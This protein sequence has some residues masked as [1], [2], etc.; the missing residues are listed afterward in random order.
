M[1]TANHEK[2]RG[3]EAWCVVFGRVLAACGEPWM[4]AR[5]HARGEVGWFEVWFK[6]HRWHLRPEHPLKASPI[7]VASS[8][9]RLLSVCVTQVTSVHGAQGMH[10]LTMFRTLWNE[11]EK[12]TR[13]FRR[14]HSHLVSR[15]QVQPQMAVKWLWINATRHPT[16]SSVFCDVRLR[17]CAHGSE[18]C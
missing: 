4:H 17:L 5:V 10:M 11:I 2:W 16:C 14:R 6:L 9:A 15:C 8:L 1:S 13:F 3:R 18:L 7:N 12:I